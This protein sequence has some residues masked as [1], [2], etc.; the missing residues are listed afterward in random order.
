MMSKILRNIGIFILSCLIYVVLF[1]IGMI[2]I[3]YSI[4]FISIYTNSNLLLIIGEN[5]ISPYFYYS[6]LLIFPLILFFF[7][8]RRNKNYAL[9]LLVS[10]IFIYFALTYFLISLGGGLGSVFSRGGT[11]EAE[12][13]GP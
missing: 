5:D 1:I 3:Y 2:G 4:L 12:G 7:F 6:L 9:I 10:G 13:I 11:P 8:K